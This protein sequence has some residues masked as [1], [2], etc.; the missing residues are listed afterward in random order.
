MFLTTSIY[1]KLN[2]HIQHGQRGGKEGGGGEGGRGRGRG[3]QGG[4]GGGEEKSMTTPIVSFKRSMN[5]KNT[6]C[7]FFM[8]SPSHTH[9]HT[10]THRY[11]YFKPMCIL[12]FPH[13]LISPSHR[14]LSKF[15]FIHI[16]SVHKWHRLGSTYEGE[17]AVVFLVWVTLFNLIYFVLHGNGTLHLG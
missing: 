13:D 7:P 3:G 4:R 5:E 15:Y 6:Q 11:N 10:C 12:S 2:S 16:Y 17:H 9:T 8:T 14:L 1:R